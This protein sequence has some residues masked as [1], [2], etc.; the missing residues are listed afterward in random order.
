MRTLAIAAAALCLVVAPP[1]LAADLAS[2]V[3]EDVFLF[4][5]VTNPKG[6]WAD[7]EQSG[8]RDMIR[9]MPNGEMQ[10]RLAAGF[11]QQ[12]ALQQLGIRLGEFF[13]A[14]SPRLAIVLPDIPDRADDMLPCLLF[15]VTGKKEAMQTLLRETVEQAIS[16]S[17]PNATFGD[18]LVQDVPL[19]MVSSGGRDAAYAFLGDILVA[20]PQAG[21]RKLVESRALRPLAANQAFTAV[22]RKLAVEK[23]LVA[24]LNLRRLLADLRPQLDANPEIARKLDDAGVTTLQWVAWA[25]RFDGRGI[26]DRIHL[27]TGP[28]K[29]GLMRLVTSLSAGASAAAMVLP[30]DC[31]AVASLTFKDGPELWQAVLGYLEEGGK[32]EHLARLDEGRQMVM[33]RMGINFDQ[34]FVGA[35]GGEIFL[36]ANPDTV[37]EYAAK[38]TAPA[39]SDFP[40]IIGLRVADRGAM[41]A[42][43]HR[44]MA[45]Q[46]VVGQGVDRGVETHAGTEISIL[47][48]P[49]AKA[50]PAYAFVG[51]YL[52][53]AR[54][55]AII[56]RCIDAAANKDALAALPQ[57]QTFLK[58][59]PAKYNGMLYA[60]VEAIL[61]AAA[62][63]GKGVPAKPPIPPKVAL[64]CQLRRT[65]AVLATGPDGITIETY[66]RPGIVGIVA[67]ILSFRTTP[68]RPAPGAAA[69]G[70]ASF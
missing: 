64:A 37:A 56:R 19:R 25:S 43:V 41:H 35:L 51:D 17:N 52:L 67:A 6:M 12:L 39:R 18:D 50:R 10:F 8:L 28:R 31:P 70:K 44:F 33:L 38:G 29:V 42:T 45:S 65:Y 57:F 58:K 30:S 23:G 16:A 7:F 36:A 14:Y 47:T 32:V 27:Y 24:Y 26:R 34:D 62:T 13:D 9:G 40:F 46:P 54:S 59:M 1:A 22:R 5:E 48:L 11:V 21:V 4:A 60:D 63:R 49:G 2:V 15:D 69:P 20:G 68:A 3:S 61:V 53:I 66:T 55:A